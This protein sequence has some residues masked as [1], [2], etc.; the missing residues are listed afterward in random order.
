MT[1]NKICIALCLIL[2]II[3]LNGCFFGNSAAWQTITSTDKRFSITIPARWEQ[4][5]NYELNDE[6]D[7]QAQKKYGDHYL[8]VLAD[9]KVDLDYSFEYWLDEVLGGILSSWENSAILNTI[10][11]Q[12]DEQPAKQYEIKGYFDRVR[13]RMLAT[14]IDGE[15]YFAQVLAW[16]TESKYK[17]SEED[18]KKIVNS[19]KGL[20]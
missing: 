20:D 13:I 1:K 4:L 15:T 19:I 11:I 16:T 17:S 12:I 9:N 6:A 8:V 3:S 2:G 10:D 18:F 14:Y 7:I 5:K